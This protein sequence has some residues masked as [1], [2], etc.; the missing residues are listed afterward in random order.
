MDPETR[1]LHFNSQEITENT[2]AAYQQELI[3]PS[4]YCRPFRA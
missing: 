3:D 2:R 1:E 4:G